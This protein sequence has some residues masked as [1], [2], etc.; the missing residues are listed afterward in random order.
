M[1]LFFFPVVAQTLLHLRRLQ[2]PPGK[3]IGFDFAQIATIVSMMS[4]I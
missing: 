4:Y 2:P 3:K 1:K